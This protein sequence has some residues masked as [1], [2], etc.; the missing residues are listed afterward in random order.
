MVYIV[1]GGKAMTSLTISK[2]GINSDL[3][4][5]PIFDMMKI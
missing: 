1:G 5:C 3:S 2:V 4:F